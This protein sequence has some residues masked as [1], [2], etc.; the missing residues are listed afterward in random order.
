MRFETVPVAGAGGAILAHSLRAGGRLFKKGRLLGPADLKA[1]S[2]AKVPSLTVVRLEAGDV[3]EDEAASRLAKA[4]AGS[5]VRVGAAFTGRANLYARA[6]GLVTFDT[7]AI[8]EI[9]LIDEAVTVATLP[10]FASVARDDMVATVKIIPFAAPDAAV[11]A[12][13]R[14]ARKAPL[15]IATFRPK[16][17]ALITT[18]LPGQKPLHDKTRASVEARL[19]PLGG[20]L[21]FE[22]SCAHQTEEVAEAIRSASGSGADVYLVMGASAISDRRDVIPAGIVAAGGVV[23]HFGMPVDPGNLLLLARLGATPVIGLPGCARSPKRNGFDFVLQRLFAGLEV[24]A[25]EIMRMGVGGLLSEIASRP[26]PRDGEKERPPRAP[27]VAAIVLAAGLSS[28]MGQNKL[29]AE[30]KGEPLI[31]R[32]VEAVRRAHVDPLIVVTGH[33]ADKLKSALAGIE[34]R[35]V[36]NPDYSEGL[37]TSLRAGLKAVPVEADAALVLLGDMPEISTTLLDHMI[38]AFSPEDGRSIC[39]ATSEGKRGNPV[40]WARRFFPDMEG[41]TGDT[42]AKHLIALHEPVVCE[43]EADDAVLRDIDTPDALEALRE[44]AGR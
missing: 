42:G 25:R 16:R 27:R 34:V 20:S 33:D 39:V 17:V 2:D 7:A 24:G 11:E 18:S 32:T 4:L 22:T 44:R 43:I 1:L 26:Q 6:A 35:F 9:N 13:E 37:S 41:I 29:L 12:A 15:R 3:P 38:A 28:R 14:L 19:A 23:S 30:V 10:A 36:S 21:A 31:R 8:E 40:L 5:D